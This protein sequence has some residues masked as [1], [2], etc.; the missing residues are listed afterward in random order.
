MVGIAYDLEPVVN[1]RFRE[2]PREKGIELA[3]EHEKRA[4]VEPEYTN[5][6]EFERYVREQARFMGEPVE[7]T[8]ERQIKYGI[9]G[10]LLS[11]LKE[12]EKEWD[13][14][15]LID[16]KVAFLREIGAPYLLKV[17]ENVTDSTFVR[18]EV[19][20][21]FK[22]IGKGSSPMVEVW[23]IPDREEDPPE[24]SHWLFKDL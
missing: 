23:A 24:K 16:K 10:Q 5:R 3:I 7:E 12:F 19:E 1:R 13:T 11:K 15:A 6:E 8:I 4:S 2:M 18:G 17:F 22:R 9:R 21:A 14:K 20:S